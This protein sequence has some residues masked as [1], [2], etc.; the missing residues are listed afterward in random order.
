MLDVANG[1]PD[2]IP[3]QDA[4]DAVEDLWERGDVTLL[5]V[6]LALAELVVE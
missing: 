3:L 2:M 1:P 6:K 4:L 5:D